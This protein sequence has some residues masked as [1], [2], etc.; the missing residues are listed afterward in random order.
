MPSIMIGIIVMHGTSKGG[1]GLLVVTFI[2]IL[3]TLA[4]KKKQKIVTNEK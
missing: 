1:L 2:L 4:R 3:L